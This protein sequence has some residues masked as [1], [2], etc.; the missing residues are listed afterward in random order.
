LAANPVTKAGLITVDINEGIVT[1]RGIVGSQPEALTAIQIAQ[2][3]VGIKDV[4]THAFY[5]QGSLLVLLLN[6]LPMPILYGE[7]KGS[8]HKRIIGE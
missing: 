8:V 1:L 7:S 3:T 6:L 2:S 4:D 5:V